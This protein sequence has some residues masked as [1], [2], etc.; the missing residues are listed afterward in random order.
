MHNRGLFAAFAAIVLSATLVE[1][2]HAYPTTAR[3]GTTTVTGVYRPLNLN[4]QLDNSTPNS[5]T[6]FYIPG[7][8]SEQTFAYTGKLTGTFSSDYGQSGTAGSWTLNLGFNAFN[9]SNY[10]T[11]ATGSASILDGNIKDSFDGNTITLRAIGANRPV[12]TLVYNSGLA[13]HDSSLLPDGDTPSAGDMFLLYARNSS[14]V[15]HVTVDNI[16]NPNYFYM[17]LAQSLVHL[18]PYVEV[19]EYLYAL[20]DGTLPAVNAAGQPILDEGGQ[21]VFR[22]DRVNDDCSPQGRPGCGSVPVNGFFA[23]TVE[24]ARFIP[25]PASLALVGLGLLGLAVGRRRSKQSRLPAA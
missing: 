15:I 20:D 7:H 17:A 1:T 8:S 22:Q 12:G 24:G 16:E 21:P 25:E 2:A 6:F 3:S 10:I 11:T 23:S 5:S 18:G 14:P 13:T 9:T 19:D 4:L